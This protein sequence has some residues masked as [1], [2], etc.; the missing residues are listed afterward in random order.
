[1]LSRALAIDNI[2]SLGICRMTSLVPVSIT[3]TTVTP[4][5]SSM[6]NCRELLAVLTN[7]LTSLT[8]VSSS[9][10]LSWGFL[11]SYTAAFVRLDVALFWATSVAE[12]ETAG[13]GWR[14]G[15]VA[16]VTRFGIR[17]LT[18]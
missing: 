14:A 4:R 13:G 5:S 1:M 12:P 3:L 8:A 18:D 2:S 17:P 16:A 6:L 15:V 10:R 9:L 7:S 11:G